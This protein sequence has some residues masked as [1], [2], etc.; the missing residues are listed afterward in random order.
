MDNPCRNSD[1]RAGVEK[2]GYRDQAAPGTGS[3]GTLPSA[4]PSEA[5]SEPPLRPFT[6]PVCLAGRMTSK[7]YQPQNWEW[8]NTLSEIDDKSRRVGRD[9]M[10]IPPQVLTAAGHGPRRTKNII[11]ALGD[12]PVDPSI[13]RHKHL[14][15]HC[16]SCAATPGQVR[17]CAIIDCPLWPYRMGRNP[18]HPQRGC[19]PFTKKVRDHSEVSRRQ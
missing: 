6:R 9:P 12:E 13:I 3:N 18:H 14:R 7:G 8:L 17:R 2:S 5:K 15:Q 10:S 19:N 11:K 1:A 16:L 4:R